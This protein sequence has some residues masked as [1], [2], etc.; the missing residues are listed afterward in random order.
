MFIRGRGR[1]E[2]SRPLNTLYIRLLDEMRKG[3]SRGGQGLGWREWEEH[4]EE[5]E[6]VETQSD[7]RGTWL[8]TCEDG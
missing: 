6:V 7:A 4:D 8:G 3:R 2:Y 5:G 1:I